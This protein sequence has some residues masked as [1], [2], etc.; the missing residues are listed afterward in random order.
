[1][2]DSFEKNERDLV[3]D[4]FKDIYPSIENVGSVVVGVGIM[5][6]SKGSN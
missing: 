6:L 5:S 3:Y 2:E 1:V 4:V